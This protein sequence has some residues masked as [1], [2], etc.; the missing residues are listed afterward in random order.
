MEHVL[1]EREF[2]KDGFIYKI[3]HILD[4]YPDLDHLGKF[5]DTWP[6][7]AIEHS[8]DPRMARYFIPAN[9]D[10]AQQDYERMLAYDRNEWCM[11]GVVAEIYFKDKGYPLARSGGLW[12]VESDGREEYLKEI[13]EE[14]IEE[15]EAELRRV[16]EELCP[17]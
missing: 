6:E 7:G 1:E 10:Y 3:K 14:Q 5:S 17:A 11:L 2:E 16:K 13:E 9:T 4:E 8:D 15:A 12:G